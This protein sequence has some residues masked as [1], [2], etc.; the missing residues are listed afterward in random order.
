ME[1]VSNLSG[2]RPDDLRRQDDH[3]ICQVTWTSEARKGDTRPRGWPT[4]AAPDLGAALACL[5]ES[6]ASFESVM[7]R[8]EEGQIPVLLPWV[9]PQLK[10]TVD[11][12]TLS[13]F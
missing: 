8:A 11:Q 4:T 12:K 9:K 6:R 3:R 5:R 13:T 1:I 10:A 7:S 2:D